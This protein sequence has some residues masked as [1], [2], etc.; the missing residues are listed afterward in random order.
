MLK[1]TMDKEF[2]EDY[3]IERVKEDMNEFKNMYTINDLKNRFMD[4]TES[5]EIYG[6]EI[7]SYKISAF[8]SGWACGNK[9]CY[10]VDMILDGFEKMFKVRFYI[11]QDYMIDL[12]PNLY[13][14]KT[15]KA[16]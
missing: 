1:I 10:A 8:D 2:V 6:A 16:C 14:V 9:T 15:F 11:D 4:E 3:Q 13:T 5:F 7:I 12:R